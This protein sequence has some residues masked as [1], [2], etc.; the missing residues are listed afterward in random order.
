MPASERGMQSA[1][2]RPAG[3]PRRVLPAEVRV[4]NLMAAA[5]GL[6]IARGIDGTTID[7]I[8]AKAGVAKGSFYH[9]FAT[10][11]DVVL[12]LRARFSQDFATQVADAVGRC[13]PDDHPSRLSAWLRAA[14]GAYLGNYALHDVV[15]HDF[16]HSQRRSAE[17]D[18]VLAP[19]EAL[20][21]AGRDAGCWS[22]PDA[23]SA[24]LVV[25]DGMHGVVDDAIAA[26]QHDPE[27]LCAGLETMF[28]RMLARPGGG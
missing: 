24:A 22:F 8:V 4:E 21:G 26:G 23:R 25:F 17:K 13:A 3:R 16:R 1:A 6:F 20:L 28:A 14:I 27:P 19:L 7:D 2:A 18:L 11:G 10:K 5:A 12:A 15:F 9:Y